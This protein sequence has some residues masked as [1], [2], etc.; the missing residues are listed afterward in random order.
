MEREAYDKVKTYQVVRLKLQGFG[1]SVPYLHEEGG[2]GIRTIEY[3]T[4]DFGG[5]KYRCAK[6]HQYR[7]IYIDTHAMEE[8]VESSS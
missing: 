3:E 7:V 2:M 1:M 5:K 8:A 4:I 6:D